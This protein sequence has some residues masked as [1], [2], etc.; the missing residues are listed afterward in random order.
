MFMTFD[1]DGSGKLNREELTRL[2]IYMNY[3]HSESNI[4]EMFMR[5]DTD[6]SGSLSFDEFISYMQDKRPKP[7]ILYGMSQI[8]YEQFMMLFHQHD[9]DHDGTR[10][11][12][13]SA[14]CGC[15]LPQEGEGVFPRNGTEV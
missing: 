13:L 10:V 8:E 4:A 3:P 15:G 5:M 9:E 12:F 2:C 6:R 1:E 14:R 11:R 7:E